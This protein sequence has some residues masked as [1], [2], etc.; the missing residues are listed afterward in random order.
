MYFSKFPV[1]RYPVKSGNTFRFVLARNILRRVALSDSLKGVDSAFIEY[2]I[3]D[4]ER[5]EHI[6]DKLYGDPQYHWLVLLTNEVIDPYHGWYKSDEVFTDYIQKKY[7][8][9]YIYFTKTDDSFLYSN[10]LSSGA[11]L[12]QGSL[13]SSVKEYHPSMCRIVVDQFGFGEGNATIRTRDGI[14]TTVTVHRVDSGISSLHHFEVQ[15]TNFDYGAASTSITVDPLSQQTGLYSY[16]G[17]VVGASANVYP[18]PQTSDGINYNTSG[19]TLPLWDTYIG[20]YMGISGSAVNTYAVSN[21]S[22]EFSQNDK[23]RT[24]KLLHPRFKT[25]AVEELES[26]MRV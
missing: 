18:D 1:V 3:K 11:T 22:Y 21:R 12:I 5:P 26:L 19:L 6:A 24:I 2:S 13:S 16:V 23:T 15:K 7:R 17:G 4:G 14:S 10:L 20:R 9:T 25:M 8:G